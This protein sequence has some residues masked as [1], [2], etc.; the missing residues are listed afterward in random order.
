MHAGA[1]GVILNVGDTLQT[2][3]LDQIGD[4]F[5]QP[6]LVDLVGQLGH[7]DLVSAVLRLHNLCF[8]ADGDLAASG[9]VGSAD[10]ASAHDDAAGR[11]IGTGQTFHQLGKLRVG[12]VDQGADRVDGLA[13][14]VRRDLGRHTDSDTARAV[15]QQIRKTAGQHHRLLETVVVVRHKINRI[16]VDVGEHIHRDLAHT[17]FRVTVGSRRVAVYGTEVAVTVHQHI[18]HGKVLR[19]THHRVIYRGVAVRMVGA[20]HGADGVGAL[21][22]GLVRLQTSLI[23]GVQNTP[24]HRL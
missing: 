18:A 2:L 7:D 19:Q 1:V 10:A 11:K 12:I 5:D 6:R 21:V 16:L 8:G 3:V 23:H 20:Q 14:V 4:I 17:R 15:D 13:E 24:V 22:V 9:G